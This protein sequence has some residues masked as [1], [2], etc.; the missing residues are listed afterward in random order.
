MSVIFFRPFY[1]FIVPYVRRGI[2]LGVGNIL[3]GISVVA[4]GFASSYPFIMVTRVLGGVGTSPQHPVGSTALA[5]YFGKARGRALA[6][7]STAANLGSLVAPIFAAVLVAHIG[8]RAI[9]W[10]VGIPSIL[11]GVACLA[12]RDTIRLN[13]AQIQKS[14]LAPMGLGRLQALSQEQKHSADL[15]GLDGR[16]R[17]PRPWHQRNLHRAPF[18]Q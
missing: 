8:W 14:K 13:P 5:S 2:I 7:H 10:I 11:M 6:F 17:R 15:V 18:H 16:R 4:T 9:F 1:G 3:L 12:L